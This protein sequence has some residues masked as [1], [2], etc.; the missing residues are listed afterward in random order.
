MQKVNINI[1]WVRKQRSP[2]PKTK[3]LSLI[4]TLLLALGYW[5]PDLI[6]ALVTLVKGN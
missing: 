5:A 2:A 6:P 1:S 3:R 4:A